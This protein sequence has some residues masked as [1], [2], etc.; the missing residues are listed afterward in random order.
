MMVGIIPEAEY[1]R[2]MVPYPYD[3]VGYP[4]IVTAETNVTDIDRPTGT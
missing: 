2:M 1:H 3:S 4:T